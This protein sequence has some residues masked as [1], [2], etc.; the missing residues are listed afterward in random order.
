M[1]AEPDSWTCINWLRKTWHEAPRNKQTSVL[2]CF[3][4]QTNF[5]FLNIFAIYSYLCTQFSATCLLLAISDCNHAC[6][7]ASKHLMEQWTWNEIDAGIGFWFWP[8]HND[9]SWNGF[10]EVSDA[11]ILILAT[12]AGIVRKSFLFARN[13]LLTPSTWGEQLAVLAKGDLLFVVANR[14][15]SVRVHIFYHPKVS[16]QNATDINQNSLNQKPNHLKTMPSV[17]PTSHILSNILVGIALVTI[18]YNHQPT[19][20]GR[21][22]RHWHFCPSPDRFGLG[23]RLIRKDGLMAL[24]APKWWTKT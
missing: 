10:L 15:K 21:P 18:T 11:V 19:E 20:V 22:M 16:E 5:E 3:R 12:S 14:F 4:N 24:H 1:A 17:S 2:G 13:L 7:A 23:C 8:Q 6:E 9:W